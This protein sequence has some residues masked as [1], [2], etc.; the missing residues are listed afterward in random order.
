MY[1]N[2]LLSCLSKALPRMY[3]DDR[4]ISIAASSI[5]ELESALNAELTNLLLHEWLNVHNRS[6]IIAKTELM[7]IGHS[8]TI[9]IEGHKI[10]RASAPHQIIIRSLFVRV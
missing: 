1:I 10:D 5:P 8:L 3:N 4:R 9:Q 7:L 6:L 2:D